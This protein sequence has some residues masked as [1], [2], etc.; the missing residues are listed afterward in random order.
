MMK[1]LSFGLC[2]ISTDTIIQYQMSLKSVTNELERGGKEV[3]L[4]YLE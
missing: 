1:W 2:N 3:A 4:A